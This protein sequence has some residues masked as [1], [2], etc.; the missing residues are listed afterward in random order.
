MRSAM[1]EPPSSKGAGI[2]GAVL[3][4]GAL[5]TVAAGSPFRYL[6]AAVGLPLLFLSVCIL[7][8]TGRFARAL[9][10]LARKAVRVEVWGQPLHAAGGDPLTIESVTL[11][12]VGLWIYLRAGSEGPRAK[13]K[14]A[15]PTSLNLDGARAEISFAGY[16]Q[17]AG[18]KVKSPEGRMRPG[19]VE[20]RLA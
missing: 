11:L 19:T 1:I 7:G 14:V 8:K 16:A 13:L 5:A 17:W 18:R 6:G 20:L 12:G 2:A 9:R 15:Q 3:G 10:P 4:L